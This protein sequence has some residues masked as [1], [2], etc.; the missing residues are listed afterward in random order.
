MKL[1]LVLFTAALACA[2]PIRQHP[3]NPQYFDWKGRPTVLIT[4]AE[5]YGAVVNPDFDYV[6]YLDTLAKAGLNYTRIFTGTYVEPAGS[7]GIERNTLGPK[8][9]RFLAP[10]ARSSEPGYAAGG[11][12]FDLSRFSDEY[13]TRLKAFLTGAGKRGVVVEVTLFTSTYGDP[14]WGVHP[15]NP[16]NNVNGIAVTDWRN[17]HTLDNGGI[18][19]VQERFVRWIVRELNGFDNVIF[20][21]QNEPWADH[22]EL[23]ETIHPYWVERRSHPN[24]VE[25]TAEKS[26]AWQRRIAQIIADEEAKLPNRHLIAQNIANFRLA[27][28]PSDFAPQ[29][30]IL[31]FHYAYPEAA[32]WNLHHGKVIGLDETGFQGT[33]TSHYLR[34]A[35]RFLMSGGGLYNNLDYS[36]SVGREDGSD[37]QAKS[38]GAGNAEF[39]SHLKV[40]SAFLHSLDL[41][42]VKPDLT[43][44]RASPGAAGRCLSAP[45][46]QYA[47]YFEGRA[48]AEPVLSIPAGPW[49]S[50]W[51]DVLNGTVLQTETVPGGGTTALKSP[52]FEGAVALRLTK[53]G[54]AR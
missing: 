32:L 5:H 46:R 13:L 47:C 17:L 27:V 30:S 48:P 11:N 16:A 49:K 4:S 43:V 20:E 41:A 26:L 9:G 34:E 18:M 1:A 8:P 50:E 31:N 40:L 38:P 14:Q 10:W 29:A 22:H 45:G 33:D 37:V 15:L 7:F 39:R 21:I 52:Q 2:Q 53:T 44:L 3:R 36:Y 35:W 25:I 12:K 24:R 51:I 28:K 54:A 42:A 19:A 23:A 6:R